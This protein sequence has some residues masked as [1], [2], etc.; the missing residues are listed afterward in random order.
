MSL[1][2]SQTGIPLQ[3]ITLADIPQQTISWFSRPKLHRMYAFPITMVF[4]G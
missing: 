1:P 4:G 2:E 3:N